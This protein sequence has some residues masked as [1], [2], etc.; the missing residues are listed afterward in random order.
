[1]LPANCATILATP[2]GDELTRSESQWNPRE[3]NEVVKIA[4][5]NARLLAARS[6]GRQ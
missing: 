3:E 6:A 4:K 2:I 1:M 5:R